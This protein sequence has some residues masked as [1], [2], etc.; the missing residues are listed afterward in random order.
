MNYE[1][2]KNERKEKWLKNNSHVS[3]LIS[4]SILPMNPDLGIYI[5]VNGIDISKDLVDDE[6]CQIADAYNSVI[7]KLGDYYKN[8][9]QK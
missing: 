1:E 8:S 7:T 9:K 6:F 2:N 3:Q 4:N 5:K